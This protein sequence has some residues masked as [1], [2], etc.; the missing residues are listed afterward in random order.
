MVNLTDYESYW[1]GIVR[2]IPGICSL[3]F[4][5]VDQDM[6]RQVSSLEPSQLPALF[7]VVPSA[8]TQGRNVDTMGEVNIAVAFLMQKYDPQREGCFAAIKQIQPL[9]QQVKRTLLDDAA[10]G[11]PV[12]GQVDLESITTLP[13]T[14]LYGMMAGWSIGLSFFDYNI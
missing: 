14:D 10:T 11:C 2:R 4:V 12:L 8:R 1:Q 3:F 9:I 7:V 6:S 5:T 13:E